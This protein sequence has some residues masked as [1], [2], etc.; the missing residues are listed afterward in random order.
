[1][2]YAQ[3]LDGVE[4]TDNVAKDIICYNPEYTF[5]ETLQTIATKFRNELK[6]G[7]ES[8]NYMRQYYDVYCLLDDQRVLDFL[9]TKDYNAHKEKRFP[10]ADLAIP[11][12]ENKAFLLSDPDLRER[13][14]T[15]YHSTRGLYYN[16]QP[17]FQEI[18]ARIHKFLDKL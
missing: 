9:G 5:V 3:N 12:N 7:V 6:S 10:K 11:L 8:K 4:V 16:G 2:D 14:A 17:Q 15:R 13:F 18:L 1:M